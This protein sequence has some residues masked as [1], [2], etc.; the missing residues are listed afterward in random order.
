MNM[1]FLVLQSVAQ[2][3]PNEDNMSFGPLTVK[4]KSAERTTDE[5]IIRQFE[6]YHRLKKVC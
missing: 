1:L 4:L 5:M 2:Y 3:W 6:V